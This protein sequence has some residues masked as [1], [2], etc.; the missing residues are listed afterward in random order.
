MSVSKCSTEYRPV[1]IGIPPDQPVRYIYQP[2]CKLWSCPY[3]GRMNGLLWAI[4]VRDGV[5]Y[6]QRNGFANW[7]FVTLTSHP[8]LHTFDSTRAVWP[9]AWKKLSMRIRRLSPGLRYVLIP[10]KHKNGRLHTH[11]LMSAEINNRWLCKNA[12]ASGLGF[13]ARASPVH[14]IYGASRY[15]TKYLTKSLSAEQW[16]PHFRRIRTS[17]DWPALADDDNYTPLMAY[18]EYLTTYPNIGLDYLAE[19]LQEK[20]GIDH[21]VI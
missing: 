16:P 18:W 14:C 6:Y 21:K 4:K 7:S 5:D 13:M 2:R 20:S 10:E 3:C 9:K 11:A 17:Q 8:K 12:A 1:L 19:G 15:V